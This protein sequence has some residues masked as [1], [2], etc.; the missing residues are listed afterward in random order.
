MT[1]QPI[2]SRDSGM[3]LKA[4]C[5]RCGHPYHRHNIGAVTTCPIIAT[6]SATRTP[7]AGVVEAWQPIETF[8]LGAHQYIWLSDGFT[9]R[10]GFWVDGEK[11]ENYGSKG[12]GWIDLGRA[13]AGGP[14]GLTFA[15][16][17]WQRLP[18]P[19]TLSSPPVEGEG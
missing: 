10:V 9:M 12:G 19:P 4:D 18:S 8:N 5:A 16:T 7:D 13:E 2:L 15:P 3:E 14:R 1:T 11:H 17:H 6:Y